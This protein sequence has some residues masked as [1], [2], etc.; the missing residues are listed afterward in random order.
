MGGLADANI[1]TNRSVHCIGKILHAVVIVDMEINVIQ[2]Q[3]KCA[4]YPE[5]DRLLGEIIL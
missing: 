4:P 2:D 3:H 5:A 1:A